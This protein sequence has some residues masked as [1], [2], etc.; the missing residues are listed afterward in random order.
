[1]IGQWHIKEVKCLYH[2]GPFEIKVE[3]L[4]VDFYLA[5]IEHIFAVGSRIF[6]FSSKTLEKSIPASVVTASVCTVRQ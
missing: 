6:G 3:V 5:S 2:C 4:P 1:M